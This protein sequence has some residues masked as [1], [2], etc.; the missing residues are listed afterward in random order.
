MVGLRKADALTLGH[1]MSPDY[2]IPC[3]AEWGE[4]DPVMGAEGAFRETRDLI[5]SYARFIA[6]RDQE[7]VSGLGLAQALRAMGYAGRYQRVTEMPRGEWFPVASSFWAQGGG[8]MSGYVEIPTWDKGQSFVDH[9][10]IGVV[11]TMLHERRH[12]NRAFL[13]ERL[14]QRWT[15]D[16]MVHVELSPDEIRSVVIRAHELGVR[17]I[18]KRL[19]RAMRGVLTAEKHS[20]RMIA[21]QLLQ[22][23]AKR[24]LIASP[25]GAMVSLVGD[26]GVPRG[27]APLVRTNGIPLS[28]TLGKVKDGRVIVG[29]T[30]DHRA[31]N[32]SH[33]GE[34]YTYLREKLEVR[35]VVS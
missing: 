11:S 19:I 32:G 27:R 5:R 21:G 20:F 18:K 3:A 12:L 10:F 1:W 15:P 25:A 4:G 16:V 33:C 22:N 9:S 8:D 35:C 30:A 14:Y 7:L 24:G 26:S 13:Q 34:I 31:L 29:L 28:F 17:E 2:M 23:W 6:H